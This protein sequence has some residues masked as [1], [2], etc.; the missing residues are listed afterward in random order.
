M[1]GISSCSKLYELSKIIIRQKIRESHDVRRNH[2]GSDFDYKNLK[3]IKDYDK[4]YA[5]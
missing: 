2:R 4:I 5:F 3:Y 1:C